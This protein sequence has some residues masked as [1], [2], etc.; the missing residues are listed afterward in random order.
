M[1]RKGKKLKGAACGPVE[2]R[3]GVF[4]VG[5][6]EDRSENSLGALCESLQSGCCLAYEGVVL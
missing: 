2:L 6:S 1:K 5:L 4:E 3:G